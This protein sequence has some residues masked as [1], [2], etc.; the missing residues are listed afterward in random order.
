MS[1]FL[2][3]SV[4]FLLLLI[5]LAAV[6]FV[7]CWR[8]RAA[9]LATLGEARQVGNL[10][11]AIQPARRIIKQVL[12]SLAV[13][14]LILALARP[15]WGV[16]ADVIETRGVSVMAVLDVSASMDAQDVLPSRIEQAK[17]ALRDLF[18]NL[19]GNELGL[20]LFA[21]DAVLQFPLTTDTGAAESFLSA[22]S[23]QSITR[24]GTALEAALRLAL[25]GFEAGR[26]GAQ[27]IVLVSDGENFE[28]DPLRAAREAAERDVTIYTLGVGGVDEGAPI[29]VYDA[30][31]QIT[32][33]KS[34]ADGS[35]A[36]SRLD[37]TRL[38]QIAELTGGQYWR[39]DGG[40]ENIR[41]LSDAIN[42]LEDGLLG[43]QSERR[44]VERFEI[45]VM[46]ALLALS[47]EMLLPETAADDAA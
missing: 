5:P 37:E 45:F 29:P 21:G 11:S 18:T 43:S 25:T 39:L 38:R 23:T 27:I 19:Q 8:V 15:V 17:F 40:A 16:E 33:Y 41:A 47:A 42:Q 20:V 35:L 32:G 14:S 26:S 30:N 28:G 9:L 34:E 7:W 6:F 3:P 46:L 22:A 12:W 36:L 2:Y 10:V 24:Q 4:L 1:G 31:G 44:G 13:G